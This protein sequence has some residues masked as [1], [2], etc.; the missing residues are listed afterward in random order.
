VRVRYTLLAV[1]LALA[2]L[3]LLG[4]DAFG[5]VERPPEDAGGAG[6]A[7]GAAS[8]GT[9]ANASS[10]SG[11]VSVGVGGCSFGNQATDCASCVEQLCCAVVGPAQDME[12]AA[13]DALAAC[14]DGGNGCTCING[15]NKCFF[16]YEK[17]ASSAAF[18]VTTCIS[19]ACAQQCDCCDD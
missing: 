8:A 16:D 17:A 2:C 10:A 5:D 12:P 11:L 9:G 3:P 18:A 1:P 15:E 4:C 13:T 14:L 19:A 7:G 6:G